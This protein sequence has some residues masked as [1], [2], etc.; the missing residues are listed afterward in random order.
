MEQCVLFFLSDD[1]EAYNGAVEAAT[2]LTGALVVFII[3]FVNVDWKVWGNL[4]IVLMTG[5]TSIL[6]YMMGITHDIWMAYSGKITF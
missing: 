1:K 5:F 6:L 3:G 2:T 4:A